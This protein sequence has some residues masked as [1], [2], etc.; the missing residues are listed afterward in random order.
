MRIERLSLDFFGH[1]TGKVLDFGKAGQ[2]SDFHVIYG[3]NEA[4][5]TTTMEA[6]LRL[7]YGFPHREPYGFQHQRQNL[8]VSGLLDI[9]GETRLLTRL[10]SRSGNLRGEADAALPETAIASHLGGLSLDDYRSLLC[11]DDDTIEKGGEDIASARGDIGRLLFS[12]AAGVADLNAVLEQARAE[13]SSLYKKRASTTR[14]AELKRELGE[15]ETNIRNLDVSAHAWRKLKDAL[16]AAKGEEAQS[17]EARDELRTEQAQIAALRR[18]LPK[19]GEMDRLTD[20]IA[21]YADY[22]ERIDI[23]PEDLVTMRTDRG[24]A[25]AELQRLRDELDDAET[26]RAVLV[27]DA[28]RLALGEQL[29]DLDELRSRMQTAVLDLPRRERAHEEALSDMARIAQDLGAPE[30]CDVTAL[31]T[32]PGE[33]AILEGLRDKMRDAAAAWETEQRE[34]AGLQTRIEQARKAHQ[35]LLGAPPQMGLVDLLKRFDVD[36][37]APAVATATQAIASADTALEQALDALA[38]G[39]CTFSALPACPADPSTAADTAQRHADLAEKLGRFDDR[40]ESL[41]EDIAAVKAKTTRLSEDAR[42]ASDEEEQEAR[43]R[44]DALWQ[45]HRETLTCESAD[46]FAPAMKTVDDINAARLAHASELGELR[47]LLQDLAD[48]EARATTAREQHD[49]LAELAR[50]LESQVHVLCSQIGLPAL[51]PSAFSD[52]V[53]LHSKAITAE[54]QRNRLVEHHR[55]TLDRAEQ[56][57]Q[58]LTPLVA[59]ETPTL[60]AALLAARRLAENERRHQE[61]V[62]AASDKTAALEEDLERRQGEQ[63]VLEDTAERT[64]AAWSAKVHELFGETLSPEQL[65]AGLGQLREL[66]EHNEKRRQ[67]ERQVDTM[68]DDQRRF[69]EACSALGVR[70]G[71]AENDPLDTFRRLRELAEQAQAD[72]SQHEELGTRLEEGATRRTE[73]EAKL[74][75]IDRKVLELGAVFPETVATSTIDALRTAVGKGLDVIVKRERVAELERQI[76][77]DLSL[78]RVEEA[79]QLLADETA[80]TLEAKALSLETDLNLAEERMSTA[81]VAR[82]NAERDLGNV[83]GGAEIAELVERRATLQIQIEEAVLNYLEWDFGLRLAE[84]AIRR[85]RDRHRSDMMAA[86]ERAFAELTN[87]AYQK[88]LTQPDGA[89]EILLAIDANGTP[90]QISDMSKGTRF[91]LYLALR[92]AAYE[93]MVAQ[94]VQLPFFCDD[95]FET[96]DED[97]T[98]AACRLMERIGRSGQAI[99]LTHHRHVVEIARDVCDTQPIIHL[100]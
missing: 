29:D 13:A 76:L 54:R 34:I 41:D 77:D 79:R 97:R 50:G 72:K 89:A 91:Q 53:A 6:Y 30:D 61:E 86:T 24:Q 45:A 80:T 36:A 49:G 75:D 62:R 8:R 87:G 12:A 68:Q 60:D 98:R 10:P 37:L 31:V 7:L 71:I 81:T 11:L 58:A 43:A 90:K 52:W 5:K 84:D 25:D 4:G 3:S 1:F 92:A 70:F 28:D 47:K 93:Q 64:A 51:S 27:I 88:L 96:F 16:Q 82:A 26:A 2:A 40:L 44:R 33:I 59:L 17:R 95:V 100:L 63:G 99:Y 74:E 23:N 20:E 83:T 14:V 85:Y 9:G 46:S 18:A 22:P 67:A 35:S 57:R 19:L 39:A 73:L 48:A 55:E 15:V 66:R 69:M 21:D 94:G 78:R 42:I 65:A 38:I 56:L 32:S